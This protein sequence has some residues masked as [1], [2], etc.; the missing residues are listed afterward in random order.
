MFTLDNHYAITLFDSG[1]DYSFVS[2]T[3]MPL[4]DIEPSNLG[5]S[6]EIEIDSGQ[7][8]EIN[9]VIQGCKLEIEGHIFDIDLIPLGHKSFDGIVCLL[10]HAPSNHHHPFLQS[11]DLLSHPLDQALGFTR[12]A[13][14]AIL[15]VTLVLLV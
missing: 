11:L 13:K 1:V 15:D 9:E 10:A 7:L 8:V 5:F 4:L 12:I 2:T 3:S 14:L 6:Y